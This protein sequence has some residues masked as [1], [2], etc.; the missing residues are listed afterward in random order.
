MTPIQIRAA[1]PDDAD[2]VASIWYPGWRDGHLGLVPEELARARTR[3][4]FW[5][6]APERV[7]DTT[8]AVVEGAVAGFVMVVADEVEQVYVGS[9]HRGTGVAAVLIEQ[10]ERLV[11]E[12]RHPEAWLAVVP[13]N[14]RARAFYQRAGW[15]DEGPF[16]YLASVNGD[17][18]AVPCHRYTKRVNR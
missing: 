9:E 17:V 15:T 8:V 14:A 4:S 1:R 10:A 13:G 7:G 2:A 5:S 16:D 11:A 6:R 12:N 3:E 18:V